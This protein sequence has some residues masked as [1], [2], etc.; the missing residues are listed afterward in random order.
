MAG[1][2]RVVVAC[3]SAPAPSTRRGRPASR[4]APAARRADRG[5]LQDRRQ[6][7]RR[8]SRHGGRPVLPAE[9]GTARQHRV[10]IVEARR[11]RNRRQEVR[12]GILHQPLD[13]AFVVP[14]AGPAEP[15]TEQIMADQFRERPRPLSPAVAA[16]PGHRDLE[17]VVE[18]RQRHAAEEGE[19]RHMPVQEGLRRLGRI[20]LHERGIRL[21][22]VHAEEVDLLR[23]PR[24]SRRPLRQ[25]PPAH[26]RVDA[27]AA[28]TS[29][30][31][32]P[33]RSAHGPSPPCSRRRTHARRAAARISASPYAAASP[34]PSG[35]PP[36]SRRSPAAAGRA[37]ASPP[38]SCA[39]SP[40]ATRT[41]TS[42]TPSRGS[43]RISAPPHDGYS[44]R[45]KRNVGR[46]RKL[47]RQTFP[48]DPQKGPA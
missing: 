45:R 15:V 2:N 40:A 21:R 27:T 26:G 16:D 32:V 31:R 17:I 34:A 37:S 23:V 4:R 11:H 18:H 22:Q 5:T 43:A 35:P 13:L 48:A 10:E 3:D 42:S 9:P 8:W 20:G 24:R 14:L 44:P 47:P 6:A 46:R 1:R 12:A 28:R 38:A 29:R 39:C 36:G 7:A 19:G 25:N 33:E 41:G 30:A